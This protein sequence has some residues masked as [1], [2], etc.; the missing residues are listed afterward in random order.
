N[1]EVSLQAFDADCGCGQGQLLL[2]DEPPALPSSAGIR[3]VAPEVFWENWNRITPA[4]SRCF[5]G[6]RA[7][8]EVRMLAQW[9]ETVGAV[10]PAGWGGG[11]SVEVLFCSFLV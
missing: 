6:P 5:K 2:F 8:G 3:A 1:P 9:R 4:T 7:V 10:T 11:E